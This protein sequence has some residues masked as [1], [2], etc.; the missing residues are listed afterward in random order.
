MIQKYR[1]HKIN[2]GIK[3]KFAV[4]VILSCINSCLLISQTT[5]IKRSISRPNIVVILAD[6]MGWGDVGQHGNPYRIYTPN[7]EKIANEGAQFDRFFV[8]PLCAPTRASLLTG[9]Y[10]LRTGVASV[11]GGLETMRTEEVTF[12]EV[13]KSAGYATGIFGKWHNGAHFPEDPNGQGFDEFLGFCA[14][15]WCNYFNTH[16][17]HNNKSVETKGFITDVLTYAALDFIEKNKN[18][19]F[20]CYIPY[21]A[22][23]G[24]FQVAEKYFQKFK[25]KGVNDKD[26]AIYGMVENMDENIGRVLKKLADLNLENNTIVLFM[27]DNGPNSDRYNG[28]MKDKKGSVNEG[29]VRVP[30][31]IRW[32][33]KIKEGTFIKQ[34]A[35]HIDILPTLL[36]LTGILKPKTLS[37]DG[38]S[39]APL[40]RNPS[41]E[42]PDRSL[43]THV[44]K[45]NAKAIKPFP[46]SLRTARYRYV[47]DNK[48][49]LLYDMIADPG[50]KTDIASEI[51]D[52]VKTFRTSYDSWF[53]NVTEKKISPEITQVGFAQAPTTELFAPDAAKEGELKYYAKS[54]FAHDWFTGFQQLEDAA[55]WSIRVVEEGNFDVLLKYNCDKSFVGSEIQVSIDNKKVKQVVFVPFTGKLYPSPDRVIRIEAYEKEWS[56]LEIGKL[57]LAKGLHKVTVSLANGKP[58]TPFELK[59]VILEKL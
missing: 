37:F 59:S 32:P 27:T 12:A 4:G 15:H 57:N 58:T 23:H 50:Q 16:L 33:G 5:E 9:R 38:K 19:P 13:F 39:L 55:I 20:L 45:D 1:D 6:D 3:M 52:T 56:K 11:T 7:M 28:G 24:P 31:F 22:P 30:F 2:F 41:I 18:K 29:G 10:H 25:S 43:F 46:G 21:N 53:S 35:A 34:L 26:A 47:R 51:P 44:L 14:G 54:G 48:K 49:D 40:L 42:W 36:E 17:Q 8:S